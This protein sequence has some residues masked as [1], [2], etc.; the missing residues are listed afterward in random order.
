ML[1]KSKVIKVID[2]THPLFDV[3]AAK[4]QGELQS[5]NKTGPVYFCGSYFRVWFPRGCIYFAVNL[6]E[7]LN[8][9]LTAKGRKE[10]SHAKFC[11]GYD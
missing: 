6:C 2:Y 11:K 9:N 8:K 10:Y 1:A 3:E 5:L 7:H 4:A